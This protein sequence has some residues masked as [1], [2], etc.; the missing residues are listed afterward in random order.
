MPPIVPARLTSTCVTSVPVRSLTVILSAPPSALKSIVSTSLR[1]MMMLPTSRVNR[2]RPPLAEMSKFSPTSAPLNSSVSM[3]SWPSTDVAAVARIPL[4][5]VVAGA[6]QG[7]VVACWPSMKSLPS[8]PSSRSAPLLPRMVSLPAPPSTVS[9]D[10]GGQVAG[11]AEDV[12]A[13]VHVEDEVLGRA[14]VER[15]RRGVE[16]VEAHARAVGGD[17]EDLGA[18]AAID[19]GGVGAVAALEQ[20][21]V[22]ARVPDHAIVAGF[23]EHL[24]VA[25]AA[26]QRVVAVAAEQ[27]VV[28]ALA[29]ERVVAGLA[30][31]LDRHR[32]RRS[33]CRCRRRR[34]ARGRQG[35][36]ASSSVIV[37][38]P[39][40]PK[41]WIRVVLATVA[42]PPRTTTRRR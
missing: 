39:A 7:R 38:L 23:A 11:G 41:T 18:V 13:A 27:Q 25:V 1:S 36:V 21:G 22:V 42:G 37:S 16:P 30:E 17:G 34:T 10:E 2:T 29:E 26:G 15:E 40:R 31:Q 19:L 32:S 8:P 12:V 33:W 14:D 35:A 4:E 9:A 3:P 24:V 20:V 6:E 28:A 5:H